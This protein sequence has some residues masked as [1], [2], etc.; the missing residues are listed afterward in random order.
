MFK[1]QQPNLRKINIRL[2]IDNI[3]RIEVIKNQTNKSKQEIINTLLDNALDL[4][5]KY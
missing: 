4:L 1:D 2:T 5:F 3:R